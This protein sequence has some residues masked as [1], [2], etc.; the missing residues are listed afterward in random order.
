M[1]RLTRLLNSNAGDIE[2]DRILAARKLVRCYS[3]I[4]LKGMGILLATEDGTVAIDDVG[5]AG[6]GRG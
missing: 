2:S 4:V 1:A 6:M 5:N 3:S